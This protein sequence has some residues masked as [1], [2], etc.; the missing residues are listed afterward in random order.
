MRSA[1]P[2]LKPS[3]SCFGGGLVSLVL[4][5]HVPILGSLDV[6]IWGSLVLLLR[7]CLCPAVLDLAFRHCGA[8]AFAC[9]I[10]A[11]VADNITKVILPEFLGNQPVTYYQ[12]NST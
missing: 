2:H 9:L 12:F 11:I 7:S 6:P 1:P 10:C 5:P 8:F 4:F 3:V